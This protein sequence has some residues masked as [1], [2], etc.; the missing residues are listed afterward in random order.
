MGLAERLAL[1]FAAG[2]AVSALYDMLIKRQV[3]NLALMGVC[4]VAT[5]LANVAI[6]AL[7]G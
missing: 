6:I 1:A 2:A 4:G 3:P 5:L 7:W